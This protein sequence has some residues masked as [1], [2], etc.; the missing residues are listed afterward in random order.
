[1]IKF[2]L[3]LFP[4]ISEFYYLLYYF[5]LLFHSLL[6]LLFLLQSN[7]ISQKKPTHFIIS[8]VWCLTVVTCICV[9]FFPSL[10]TLGSGFLVLSSLALVLCSFCYESLSGVGG[11]DWHVIFSFISQ[12]FSFL[13]LFKDLFMYFWR[14]W[15]CIAMLRLSLVVT[16]GAALHGGPQA[17]GHMGSGAV[18]HR[19]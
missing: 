14:C 6:G 11:G 8:G 13:L 4:F 16:S 18:A 2:C 1:M 15:V 5:L 7:F 10:F 12:D 9:S 3:F 17:L 19:L